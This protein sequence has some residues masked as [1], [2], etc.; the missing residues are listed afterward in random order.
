[1][2]PARIV[3]TAHNVW[4]V[5]GSSPETLRVVLPQIYAKVRDPNGDKEFIQ[6]Y[7]VCTR[8]SVNDTQAT[9]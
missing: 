7:M 8:L 3:P 5:Y 4:D 9:P 2:P 6:N 1:M